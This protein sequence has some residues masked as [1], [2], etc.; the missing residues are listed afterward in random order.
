MKNQITQILRKLTN[1][2]MLEVETGIFNRLVK[3]ENVFG[4]YVP[5]PSPKSAFIFHLDG[6]QYYVVEFSDNKFSIADDNVGL[7][8]PID[9]DIEHLLTIFY[10]NF[11]L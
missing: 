8:L 3:M 4:A 10:R 7:L 5:V 6:I 2:P 9:T 11:S 1:D